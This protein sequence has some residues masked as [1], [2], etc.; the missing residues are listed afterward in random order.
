M[1]RRILVLTVSIVL[2]AFFVGCGGRSSEKLAYRTAPNPNGCYVELFAQEQFRGSR[3]FVNG[4][5]QFARFSDLAPGPAQQEGIRS[6]RTGSAAIVT[7][8]GESR[9]RG[10]LLRLGPNQQNAQLNGAIGGKGVSLQVVCNNQI[11]AR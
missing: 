6:V 9:Y 7:V 10:S 8:W 11:A 5:S 1:G 2:L 4:P 3:E